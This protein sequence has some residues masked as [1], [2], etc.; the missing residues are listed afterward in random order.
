MTPDVVRVERIGTGES[1]LTWRGF[2]PIAVCF[3]FLSVTSNLLFP[4]F[5]GP[6]EHSH[7]HYARLLAQGKGLPVQTD[8]DRTAD[9][10]G[11][12]PPLYYAVPAAVLFLLDPDR[13][14]R[15][16]HIGVVSFPELARMASSETALP[17][18]NPRWS[19][20]GRGKD[21]NL[22]VHPA[23][24]PLAPGPVRVIHWMRLVSTLCGLASLIALFLLAREAAPG[25][26]SVQV[27]ALAVAAFNPQFVYISGLLNN[28]NLVTAFATL[29]LWRIAR[30]L[31]HRQAERWDA[32]LLGALFGLGML[33]KPN[34]LFL[35]IPIV[36]VLW[37]RSPSARAFAG[38]LALFLA[39]ALGIAGWFFVRNAWLYGGLDFFGWQTRAAIHPIFVLPRE[40]RFTYLRRF[41]APMLFTTYWGRFGW[42]SLRLPLWQYVSY[43]LLAA[44]SLATLFPVRAGERRKTENGILPL[45]WGT[46]ALNLGSLVAFNFLFWAEQGRLLFPSIGAVAMLVGMGIDRAI[47]PWDGSARRTIVCAL[48]ALLLA[49][50]L[51]AQWLVVRPV[52]FP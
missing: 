11:F 30:L 46:V 37:L 17:G 33:A 26:R 43:G 27:L 1:D 9:T 21:P 2:I 32:V 49:S 35:A 25:R 14:A 31:P 18:M 5:D 36:V 16:R 50:A 42:L 3:V 44:T 28:D 45:L 48:L 8:P 52:Y 15:I 10:E 34:M 4:P 23:E 12:G 20:F 51:F 38:H 39:I 40:V 6:D 7:F 19:G 22:F 24:G 29:T 13:G 41:F 47:S